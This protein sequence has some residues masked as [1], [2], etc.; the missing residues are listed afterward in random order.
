[1]WFYWPYLCPNNL[2]KHQLKTD[3]HSHTSKLEKFSIS[4]YWTA[5]QMK[6]AKSN[7][8]WCCCCFAH[9]SN[10]KESLCIS[11]CTWWAEFT[12]MTFIFSRK[13]TLPMNLSMQNFSPFPTLCQYYVH[14]IFS[15]KEK[16]ISYCKS[17]PITTIHQYTH[18]KHVLPGD[19]CM[20]RCK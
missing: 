15:I 4:C 18:V 10:M 2:G 12:L 3:R 1:M 9:N 5:F 6:N 16:T 19:G 11:L 8:I 7:F 20:S 13:N 14:F 17:K